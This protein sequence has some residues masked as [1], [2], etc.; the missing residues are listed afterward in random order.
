MITVDH[1][2]GLSAGEHH[3]TL[4]QRLRVSYIPFPSVRNCAVVERVAAKVLT[5]VT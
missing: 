2:G 4:M 5:L 1:P 3:M